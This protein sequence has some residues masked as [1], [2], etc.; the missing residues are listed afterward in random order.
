MIHAPINLPEE[1]TAWARSRV[2]SGDAPSVEAYF[3]ELARRD[4]EQ[5]EEAAWLQA[6]ID[7]GEASGVS[8]LSLD[9][10]FDEVEAKYFAD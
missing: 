8:P 1:A 2:E 6:E 9:E 4:R 10:I 7:K 5:A 3:A